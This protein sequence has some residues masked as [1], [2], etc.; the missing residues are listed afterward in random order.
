MAIKDIQLKDAFQIPNLLSLLRPVLLVFFFIFLS[1]PELHYFIAALVILFLGVISDWL[2]GTLARWMNQ[3]SELGKIL[4]P[5][6]DKIALGFGSLAMVLYTGL[7]WWIFAV[8]IGRDLLILLGGIILAKKQ[9]SVAMANVYGKINTVL[10]ALMGL[11]FII[12][13][14]MTLEGV[15]VTTQTLQDYEYVKWSILVIV[16][17]SHII[18]FMSYALVFFQKNK[19]KE[20]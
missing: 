13:R 17:I 8:I 2:D 10:L 12:G 6:C 19:K 3:V 5:I 9:Q 7:P 14:L 16:T 1:I 15:E 18:S 11:I 4:D 20:D